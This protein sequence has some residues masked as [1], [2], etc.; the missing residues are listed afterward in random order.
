MSVERREQLDWDVGLGVIIAEVGF[1]R[2]LDLLGVCGG[3]QT[4][5]P[6]A[7]PGLPLRSGYPVVPQDDLLQGLSEDRLPIGPWR[8]VLWRLRRGIPIRMAVDRPLAD[9]P[10]AG[11]I[12]ARQTMWLSAAIWMTCLHHWRFVGRA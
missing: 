8:K 9:D 1:G 7:R 11:D 12:T 2:P 4:L 5:C 3:S 10:G 6:A